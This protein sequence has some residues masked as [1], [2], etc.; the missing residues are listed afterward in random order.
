[1]KGGWRA[2]IARPE[3]CTFHTWKKP[4]FAEH[5]EILRVKDRFLFSVETTGV[6]QPKDVLL[7]SIGILRNRAQSL[8][9]ALDEVCANTETSE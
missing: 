6:L 2:T 3:N 1:M 7:Q 9:D 5:L 4:K 8:L